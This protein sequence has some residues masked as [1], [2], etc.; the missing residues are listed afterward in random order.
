MLPTQ[1]VEAIVERLQAKHVRDGGSDDPE[2]N[3]TLEKFVAVK[4]VLKSHPF[5]GINR[6]VQLKPTAWIA[7]QTSGSPMPRPAGKDDFSGTRSARNSFSTADPRAT[8]TPATHTEP[9][10]PLPGRHEGSPVAAAPAVMEVPTEAQFILKWGGELTELGEAQSALLGAR[11]RNTLYPGEM[12]G[13]LRLHSTYRHDLK[14]YSSDEGRVQMTAA[15]FAKGFLDLE[16]R[17]TPILASLVSKHKSITK[18]LDDT[19]EEGRAA[20]DAAKAVIHTVLTSTNPLSSDDETTA[21]ALSHAIKEKMHLHQSAAAA[22]IGTAATRAAAATSTSTTTPGG[23]SASIA[24]PSGLP[25]D[26]LRVAI[27]TAD[28]AAVAEQARRRLSREGSDPEVGMSS[29]PAKQHAPPLPPAVLAPKVISP[30]DCSPRESPPRMPSPMADTNQSPSSLRIQPPRHAVSEQCL[31]PL[32]EAIHSKEVGDCSLLRGVELSLRQLGNPREA[33]HQLHHLVDRLTCELRARVEACGLQNDTSPGP[34]SP[35]TAAAPPPASPAIPAQPVDV[36]AEGG[37]PEA[38]SGGDTPVD[39][40]KKTDKKKRRDSWEP[41]N[42]E[43]LLLH[44]GRWAKL[45]REFFKPKKG[46]F[47]TTKIPD[48]YDNAMYDM[49]HNQHLNLLSLPALYATARALAAYV[50]PQEYGAQPDD[51]VRTSHIYLASPCSP[52]LPIASPRISP[53]HLPASPHIISPHL[54]VSSPRISPYHLT[55]SSPHIALSLALSLTLS[56][57]V[58]HLVSPCL[59]SHTLSHSLVCPRGAGAHRHQHRLRHAAQVT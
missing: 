52:H 16:G 30:L 56:L 37:L 58:S 10:S 17:L 39:A 7:A 36:S 2:G 5:S 14:I 20:M 43:T 53:Y 8:S 32:I 31:S 44:Y 29:M 23:T 24:P 25:I 50:V 55:I 49:L 1:R 41:S 28:T 42:A 48:L 12:S 38:S 3:D 33:L 57:L 22:A 19:P 15:A 9:E 46:A 13:V 18:M 21:A 45:K 26:A 51:K 54:P 40:D 27:T 6:K 47:D 34:F 35:N 59:C 4:Q 11:F